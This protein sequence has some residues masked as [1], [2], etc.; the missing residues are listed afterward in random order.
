MGCLCNNQWCML[1]KG[2]ETN[3]AQKQSKPCFNLELRSQQ[4]NVTQ[5]KALLP[6]NQPEV[7]ILWSKTAPVQ[8][9]VKHSPF[10]PEISTKIFHCDSIPPL[11]LAGALAFYANSKCKIKARCFS[12]ALAFLLC[13][14]V[15]QLKLCHPKDTD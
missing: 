5:S 14:G 13:N 3:P 6:S 15:Q 11:Q 2:Y 7:R 4:E 8:T 1:R 10:T 12:P 9:K